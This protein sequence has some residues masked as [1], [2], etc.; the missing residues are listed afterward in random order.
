MNHTQKMQISVIEKG[1]GCG[2]VFQPVVF[3]TEE[4]IYFLVWDEILHYSKCIVSWKMEIQPGNVPF[5]AI[6]LR[7]SKFAH[8]RFIAECTLKNVGATSYELVSQT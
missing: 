2:I 7:M 3:Q 6:N 4:I 5:I 1:C 8:K